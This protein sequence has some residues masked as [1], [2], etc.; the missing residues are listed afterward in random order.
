[1]KVNG[2]KTNAVLISDVKNYI[3]KAFTNVSDERIETGNSMKILGFEFFLDV[4]MKAQ[5]QAIR[6]KFNTRKWILYHL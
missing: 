6:R 5:V 1:M 4:G 2:F 3:A